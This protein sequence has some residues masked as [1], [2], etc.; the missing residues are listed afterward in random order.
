M[1]WLATVRRPEVEM[2]SPA[3]LPYG[4]Q[5]ISQADIDAVVAVLK[6]DFLTQGPEVERFEA[7]LAQS[8]GEVAAIRG[9]EE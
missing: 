8:V 3:F 5:N 4:R 2:T 6:S 7:A 1:A 9:S